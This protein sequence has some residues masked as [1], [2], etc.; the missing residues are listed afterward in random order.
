M[1]AAALPQRLPGNRR[2][3]ILAGCSVKKHLWHLW[4]LTWLFAPLGFLGLYA[5]K[6]GHDRLIEWLLVMPKLDLRL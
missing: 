1:K 2:V 3:A 4:L 6:Y 5:S